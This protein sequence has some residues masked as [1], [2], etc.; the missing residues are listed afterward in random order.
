M[1]FCGG[2]PEQRAQT[3]ALYIHLPA[4]EEV[5]SQSSEDAGLIMVLLER[6]EKQRLPR[7]LDIKEKVDRGG[8][9]DD[10]DMAFLKEVF[11][12]TARI[13][14]LLERHPEYEE[15]VARLASLYKEITNKAP[16]NEKGA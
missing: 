8:R 10:F 9:L 13:Q 14:P 4:Q 6:L 1:G 7:A 16:E 3:R 5:V 12:D 11:A 15:L 2:R